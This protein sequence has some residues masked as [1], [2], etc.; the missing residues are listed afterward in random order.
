M[1]TATTAIRK[2]FDRKL[3]LINYSIRNTGKNKLVLIIEGLFGYPAL[4][5]PEGLAKAAQNCL[6]Q[7]TK[8]V[9]LVCNAQSDLE[10]S[11]TIKRVD[12]ISDTLC[13]VLDPAEFIRNVHPD[14][15]FVNV[16]DNVSMALHNFLSQLNT[17]PGLYTV[18]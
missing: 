2:G 8:L 10:I 15:A 9:E 1:R 5:H 4:S 14:E 18:S 13:S 17:H 3:N 16:A 6:Q 11:K 12:A 7:A